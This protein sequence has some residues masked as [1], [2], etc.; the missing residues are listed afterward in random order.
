[1]TQERISVVVPAYNVADWLPR[2]LDSLM[3]QTH[4]AL[5]IIVVNDGSTDGTGAVADSYS[6]GD[7]RIRVIHKENGGVTSARLCGVE[8]ASGDWIGFADA[9]DE[10]EPDMYAHLLRNAQAHDADIT[11]CGH[12]VIF[13]DG[14]IEYVHNTGVLRVQDRKTG[15]Q[16]LMDGG[17]IDASLCTKLYRRKLA[18]GL[19]EKMDLSVKNNEDYLMNYHLFMG[20]K[21]SVFEDFCPYRYILRRGSA[22]YQKLNA[23]ML[24]DPIRVR[25]SI[26]E[27][28]PEELREDARIALMRNCLFAYAQL[29]VDRDPAYADFRKQ[30]RALI[31]EQR[32]WFRLLSLRNRIL[33]SMICAAPW[34]FHVAYNGY[35]K[36]FQ[37][38]EQ[39]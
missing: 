33:S 11:H 9:D 12:R 27:M 13:P 29:T 28:V 37:K 22:S 39:H 34:T 30:A 36:L 24:F 1:M 35:V 15:L 20:A 5:E 25:Q 7:S 10:I 23:H 21:T 26:L 2:C 31:R 18:D 14:R 32:P 38:E 4:E 16:D 3:A 17:L 6:A 8:A 19:R